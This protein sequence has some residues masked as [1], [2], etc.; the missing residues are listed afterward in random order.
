VPATNETLP[1]LLVQEEDETGA[2][3]AIKQL[4]F[5]AATGDA[6]FLDAM[7]SVGDKGGSARAPSGRHWCGGLCAKNIHCVSDSDTCIGIDGVPL[8]ERSA[9]G[10]DG[11]PRDRGTR[12]TGVTTP[13]R[14]FG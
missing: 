12:G 11:R 14:R 7:A 2:L 3:R 5:G 10:W 13:A 9:D 8:V 1:R 6:L 4:D